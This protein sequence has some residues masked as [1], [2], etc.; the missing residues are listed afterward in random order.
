MFGEVKKADTKDSM[1]KRVPWHVM[2][3]VVATAGR[4]YAQGGDA[5]APTVASLVRE[6]NS[7]ANDLILSM[8]NHGNLSETLTIA[9][10]LGER[11]DP[12]IGSILAGI[13]GSAHGQEGY[14]AE[15]SLRV[16]LGGF[17]EG[18]DFLKGRVDRARLAANSTEVGRLVGRLQDFGDP[19]LK[20]ELLALAFDAVPK[21][22]AKVAAVEGVFLL[23]VLEKSGGTLAP[24]RR[25]EALAYLG[26]VA[27]L[28]SPVLIEQT[29]SL[30]AA[31][32]DADFV[33]RARAVAGD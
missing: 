23:G 8:M 29:V 4:L 21:A 16:L 32:R 33:R 5:T 11:R 25:E 10:A 24:E 7:S 20:A 13:A 14:L 18:G 9:K 6:S 17:F 28:K 26:L 2:V 27:R 12:S 30:I 1:S 15:L 22:A 3:L 19:L 31:S